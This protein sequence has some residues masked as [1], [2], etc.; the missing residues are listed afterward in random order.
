MFTK[1]KK[2]NKNDNLSLT[3]HILSGIFFVLQ[4]VLCNSACL[5]GLTWSRRSLWSQKLTHSPLLASQPLRPTPHYA[6]PASLSHNPS[7]WRL[8][9][10]GPGDRKL[11]EYICVYTQLCHWKHR[12]A[13]HAQHWAKL[14][15]CGTGVGGFNVVLLC[16]KWVS[17]RHKP[18]YI[19]F[20][21]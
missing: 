11:T 12:R 2:Q 19:I 21:Q 6:D 15:D 5:C 16:R 17:M 9:K 20:Y 14:R 4:C 8:F 18:S 7:L 10:V 3:D 1:Q 13:F